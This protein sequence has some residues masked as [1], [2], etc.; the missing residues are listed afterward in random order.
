MTVSPVWG[1]EIE[2]SMFLSKERSRKTTNLQN[3]PRLQAPL[4]DTHFTV[5]RAD[6]IDARARGLE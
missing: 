4:V 6:G 1:A 3:L 2:A 5:N